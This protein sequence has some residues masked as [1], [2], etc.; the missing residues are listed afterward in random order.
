M[1]VSGDPLMVAAG[2]FP[3]LPLPESFTERQRQEEEKN[4]T[5]RR[6]QGPKNHSG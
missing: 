2:S 4:G 3:Y 6:T 1:N 5:Q